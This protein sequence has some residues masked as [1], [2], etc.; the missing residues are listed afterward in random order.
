MSIDNMSLDLNM[1]G[2]RGPY[3]KYIPYYIPDYIPEHNITLDLLD[4]IPYESTYQI[5]TPT[6]IYTIIFL[7]IVFSSIASLVNRFVFNDNYSISWIKSKMD[8]LK[9]KMDWL[10]SKMDWLKAKYTAYKTKELLPIYTKKKAKES[11]FIG[12]EPISPI[13][14]ISINL[15]RAEKGQ[16]VTFR[17][18]TPFNIQIKSN[19]IA[20]YIANDDIGLEL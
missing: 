14:P 20:N 5:F 17:V 9:S 18:R 7:I 8:W 11:P 2:L 10:K 3:P 13:L 16:H 6:E 1:Y 19:D 12:P 15:D 4:S